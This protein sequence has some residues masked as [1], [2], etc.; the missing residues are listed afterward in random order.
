MPDERNPN[1]IISTQDPT[2]LC[3]R[4]I[5]ADLKYV[6]HAEYLGETIYF[7][8]ESCLDAF[9]ADPDRFFSAHKSIF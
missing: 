6:P 5:T 9:R 2:M 1:T 7:C 4:R 3:G 8:A